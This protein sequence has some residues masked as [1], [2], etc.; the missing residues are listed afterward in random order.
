VILSAARS[1]SFSSEI[2]GNVIVSSYYSF[3][4]THGFSSVKE[5]EKEQRELRQKIQC[6][7]IDNY[8]LAGLNHFLGYFQTMGRLV[9][10]CKRGIVLKYEDMIDDWEQFVAGLTRYLEFDDAVL[11]QIYERSRP[12]EAEDLQSHRRSGKPAHTTAN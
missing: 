11:R 7:T 2:R 4:Y 6:K 12:L 10:A 9:R 1:Q 8:A 3:G 5:I